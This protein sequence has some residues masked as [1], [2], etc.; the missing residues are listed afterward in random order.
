M[1]LTKLGDL[2]RRLVDQAS[3]EGERVSFNN[4]PSTELDTLGVLELQAFLTFSRRS[5]IE[6]VQQDWLDSDPQL[7]KAA[8]FADFVTNLSDFT[9]PVG[10]EHKYVCN[11][12]PPMINP[13]YGG[14]TECKVNGVAQPT[15]TSNGGTE[16]TVK[17]DVY[18]Q[19]ALPG[20][21]LLIWDGNDVEKQSAT[22]TI[23][24]VS[25]FRCALLRATFTIDNGSAHPTEYHAKVLNR[26]KVGQQ[27]VPV[28]LF[29]GI[30]GFAVP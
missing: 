17:L 27:W 6:R 23:V 29:G 22:P 20:C 9:W 4:D 10:N 11:H 5:I 8:K 13:A 7:T 14:G 1:T 28:N 24:A 19:G 25:T 12:K 30:D 21:Q 26:R 2:V 16:Y 3:G 15:V 18:A